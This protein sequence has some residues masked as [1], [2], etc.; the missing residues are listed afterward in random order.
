MLKRGLIREKDS[1]EREDLLER[2]KLLEVDKTYQRQ[3][4][5]QRETKHIMER[6]IR[7]GDTK[8]FT[9]EEPKTYWRGGR[10]RDGK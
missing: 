2:K 1:L 7:G 8:P 9:G 3:K 5:Y 10:V 6:F 4:T